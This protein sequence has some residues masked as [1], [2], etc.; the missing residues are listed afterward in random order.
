MKLG[1]M[2]LTIVH[3]NHFNWKKKYNIRELDVFLL[4]FLLGFFLYHLYKCTETN[5]PSSVQCIFLFSLEFLV[6][7][8]QISRH[9][10]NKH[11]NIFI[12]F[13]CFLFF[14]QVKRFVVE[15]L[16]LLKHFVNRIEISF[17]QFDWCSNWKIMLKFKMSCVGTQ[18]F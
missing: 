12:F 7:I 1:C 6:V 5:S 11:F 10:R 4:L 3:W 16:C 15:L 14:F 13:S 9:F 18:K 2:Y 8:L 17:F